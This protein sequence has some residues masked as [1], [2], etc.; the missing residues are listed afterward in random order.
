MWQGACSGVCSGHLLGAYLSEAAALLLQ[1]QMQQLLASGA[2]SRLPEEVQWNVRVLLPRGQDL[3]GSRQARGA[4]GNPGA[5]PNLSP[6]VLASLPLAAPSAPP[7]AP[8]VRHITLILPMDHDPGSR[9]SSSEDVMYEVAVHHDTCH[10]MVL[11]L[12]SVQDSQ[13]VLRV[14]SGAVQ[15]PTGAAAPGQDMAAQL[16]NML[17]Q[18]ALMQQLQASQS[19]HSQLLQLL[20]LQLVQGSTPDQSGKHS[21]TSRSLT[22]LCLRRL[23]KTYALS[24]FH[25]SAAVPALR[26]HVASAL[27][28]LRIST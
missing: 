21:P 20:Q 14:G 1:D 8:A 5:A 28:V 10:D 16:Q 4:S 13:A 23:R 25:A 11:A 22:F 17:A 6:G 27:G 15:A 7:A 19:V 12:C 18:A 3:S 24:A 2:I 9:L 26:A